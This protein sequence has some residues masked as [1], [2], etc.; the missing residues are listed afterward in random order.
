MSHSRGLPPRRYAIRDEAL[1][2]QCAPF[3]QRPPAAQDSLRVSWSCKIAHIALLTSHLLHLCTSRGC[4]IDFTTSSRPPAR[5]ARGCTFSLPLAGAETYAADSP[6]M[7]AVPHLTVDTVGAHLASAEQIAPGLL[8]TQPSASAASSSASSLPTL[9]PLT[10]Y[11]PTAPDAVPQTQL[12][13]VPPL[14]FFPR[15]DPVLDLTASSPAQEDVPVTQGSSCSSHDG[16][17]TGETTE[18]R[19]SSDRVFVHR[20]YE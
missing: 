14:P 1:L 11:T 2:S 8:S 17:S 6:A 4:S 10:L 5:F 16:Q 15:P 9:S 12:R 13:V 18:R 3:L 7:R 19:G 20:L